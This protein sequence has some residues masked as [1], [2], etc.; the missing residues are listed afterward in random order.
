MRPESQHLSQV[1]EDN[2][3]IVSDTASAAAASKAT[4]IAAVSRVVVTDAT[5][6]AVGMLH[7]RQLAR[8]GEQQVVGDLINRPVIVLPQQLT[9]AEALRTWPFH[10]LAGA[11]AELA[12]VVVT[13]DDRPVG[14]WAGER[15]YDYTGPTYRG[16]VPS[17]VDTSLG[18]PI[19]SIGRLVRPC[20]FTDL[21]SGVRCGAR[22]SFSAKPKPLPA[23]DNPKNLTPHTFDW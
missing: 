10:E 1:A 16:S 2:I 6:Q 7:A 3:V 9:V 18:G 11:L 15:L 20:A 22:R 13:D 4:A 19:N 23:C 8:A 17:F 12:G 14:V 21:P 5:G